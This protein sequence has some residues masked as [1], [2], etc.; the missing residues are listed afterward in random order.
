MAASMHS[1]LILIG[2]KLGLYRAMADGAPVTAADLARRTGTAERYVR[3]W[4]NAN[5]AGHY[6]EYDPATDTYSMTPEQAFALA[7]DDTAVHLPGFYH[8]LAS[9]MKDEEKLTEVFRTG[10]GFGW[11]EHEK[12]L[13]EGCE[14]F[15]R[16]GYLANLTTSWI[17]ALEGV[18][19]KLKA[20]ARVADVGCGHGASTLLMAQTYPNSEFYG[21]DYHTASI[22][23]AQKK[24]AAAGVGDRVHFETAPAK[25]FPGGG[26]DFVACFDCLHDMGDPT[27]AAT[28]VRQTLAPNGTWMIVEPFAGDSV[29]SNLNPIGRLYYSASTVF[30]VPASLSQEV[31]LGLGAQ[32]GEKRIRQV[33]TD[34]GFTHFRRATETPFNLVFEARP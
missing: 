30:C 9:C 32:A 5:A 19:A 15:F 23:Q 17:P 20:G 6:V 10:K 16:P 26:Y 3:E 2:D 14:R 27:G 25:S 8:M 13:F 4:L 33:V 21:F 28:H 7:E 1:A 29:A 11:H 22:E 18:D 12:G 24:A 34:G 31:G